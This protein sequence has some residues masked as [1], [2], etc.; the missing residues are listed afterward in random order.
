MSYDAISL[1]KSL[2]QCPS[3]TPS[4]AGCLDILTKALTDAGF[5]CREINRGETKN[6]WAKIGASQPSILFCGH[7]DVVP[8][9]SA[10]WKFPPFEPT[11][12]EGYLYGRGAQDMKTSDAAFTA[13][14]CRFVLEY[15]NFNG[16]ISFLITSD[17][18]GDG[19][20]GTKFALEALMKT[21]EAP[22][23][24]IVGEPSCSVKLGDTIKN[25][26]RGSLNGKLILKGIQGHVAYP[27]KVKNPIH[28]VGPLIS[29]LSSEVWD[30]G[31]GPFPPT[32]FQ[33]SNIHAGTGAVNVVP[34]VCEITF[35]IRYNPAHT[36]KSL[37]EK[38]ESICRGLGLDYSVA[39]Q[40][41]AEP[42][43]AQGTFLTRRLSKA[44]T[45]VTGIEPVLSTSGGTSDGRFVKNWCPDIVE[46][47]PTNDRIHKID[48][49]VELSQISDLAEIYYQTL[50]NIFLDQT[51]E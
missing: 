27:E 29:R 5:Q 33:I 17:E 26:R 15:P 18:E 6:L 45:A 19:R 25:G 12:S 40:E 38:I 23:C 30:E 28:M 34:P 41:S 39:W 10:P 8:A 3:V 50:R 7:V 51:H 11:E 36:A 46:F 9:G 2:I 37:E 47:G 44:I 32:S 4:D 16:S 20:D 49:R 13:A 21:E 1:T 24:C 31:F 42:F 48:E 35:N 14:A 43:F 22:M